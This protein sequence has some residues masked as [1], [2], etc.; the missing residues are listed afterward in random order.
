MCLLHQLA[1]LPPHVCPLCSCAS[2]QWVV[3]GSLGL[4]ESMIDV[5][6]WWVPFYYIAKIAFLVYC[7]APQTR[8]AAVI[9]RVALAPLFQLGM[10]EVNEV[11]EQIRN[12]KRVQ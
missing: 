6:F 7:F 10:N 1:T 11:R 12:K 3:Y 5:V 2:S 8:G 9:Y 4:F